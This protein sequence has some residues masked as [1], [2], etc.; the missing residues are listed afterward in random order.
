MQVLNVWTNATCVLGEVESSLSLQ[1]HHGGDY[2]IGYIIECG[3]AGFR[4][5]WSRLCG[6]SGV[7]AVVGKAIENSLATFRA[8]ELEKILL[9][10]IKDGCPNS[11]SPR[12]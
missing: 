6:D 3:R 9:R 11:V 4:L 5:D 1:G 2:I 8:I 10:P 12:P 7:T